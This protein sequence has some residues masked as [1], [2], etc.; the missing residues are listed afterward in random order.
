VPTKVGGVGRVVAESGQGL[1]VEGEGA[2]TDRAGDVLDAGY[3]EVGGDEVAVGGVRADC[4][5]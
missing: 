4:L 5:P 1:Q 2:G 3:G